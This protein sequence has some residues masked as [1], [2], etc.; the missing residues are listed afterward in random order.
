[1]KYTLSGFADEIDSSVSKQFDG[2]DALG[3]KWFEIRGVDGEN[4]GDITEEKAREVKALA[5][6]RG[7]AVSSIGSPIGKISI[8]DPLDPANFVQ[9]AAIKYLKEKRPIGWA[10]GV[11]KEVI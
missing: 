5:D 3:M 2:L 4:I 9:R 6:A 11:L 8:S 1:M 7:I 10:G